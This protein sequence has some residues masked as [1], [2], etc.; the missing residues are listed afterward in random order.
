MVH[1]PSSKKIQT[2][3]NKIA[4]QNTAVS[5]SIDDLVN[6][7]SGN[8]QRSDWHEIQKTSELLILTSLIL[9]DQDSAETS[10]QN[11]PQ[12]LREEGRAPDKKPTAARQR[13]KRAQRR[14][15]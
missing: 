8:T 2:L 7:A 10:S 1:Q 13:N 5:S 3:T 11:E 4:E 12:N 9:G 15:H 6:N 14:D